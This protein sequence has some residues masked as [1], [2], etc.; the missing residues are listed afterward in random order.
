MYYKSFEALLETYSVVIN[1]VP[2][3]QNAY[4]AVTLK[5]MIIAPATNDDIGINAWDNTDD[6]ELTL[7][8]IL[9]STRRCMIKLTGTL[10]AT[11]PSPMINI[12]ETTEIKVALIDISP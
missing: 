2:I 6:T 10:N 5:F 7:P 12:N 1:T 8:S 11:F 3:I 9:R 4:N